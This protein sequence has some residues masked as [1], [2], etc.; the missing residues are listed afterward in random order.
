MWAAWLV[1][2]VS[3]CVVNTTAW[4]QV[5]KGGFTTLLALVPLAFSSSDIFRTF[6]KCFL[7]I[8]G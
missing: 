6:F 3:R 7:C 5:L 8:V 2:S 4:L 1:V